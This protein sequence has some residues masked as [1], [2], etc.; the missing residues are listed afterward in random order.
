MTKYFSNKHFNVKSFLKY[1]AP[2]LLVYLLL[3][4]ISV[5]L[6]CSYKKTDIHLYINHFVGNNFVNLFFYY[7]TYLGDG[8]VAVF[9]LL[10]ILFYNTRLGIYCTTSFLSATVV[11]QILKNFFFSDADRPSF[12]FQY[13]ERIELKVVEG[14]DL[15]IH[16]SFPSGHSTQA[17]AIFMCLAFVSKHQL[18]K[19][20]F[21]GLAILT[22][23]S[24]VYLSQ[25][26]LVDITVGSVIGTIFSILFYYIFIAKNKL[27]ALNKPLTEF[28][29]R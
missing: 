13:F 24:R 18:L 25:H 7:I 17:F 22:A 10:V 4:G 15:H 1:N 16:N 6:M 9:M 23:L 14:V 20:L 2:V 12:I 21:F 8:T 3:L 26:W 11:S 5:F 27:Q 19:F 28:V 29:K